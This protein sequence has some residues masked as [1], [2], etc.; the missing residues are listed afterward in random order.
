[1]NIGRVAALT[2]AGRMHPAGLKAFEARREGRSGIYSYEQRDKA[3]FDP[4][5]E[6]RFRA[7]KR[8]WAAFEAMPRSYRQAAIRWVMTGKKEETRER[9][10]ATLVEDTAAG[11]RVGP[12]APRRPADAR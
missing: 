6:K 3:V 10:F 5:F 8:A 12:L 4:A 1:V 9:R 7:K 11:R 2:E